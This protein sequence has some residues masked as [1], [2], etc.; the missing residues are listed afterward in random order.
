MK[1]NCTYIKLILSIVNKNKNVCSY[2]M[3][4]DSQIIFTLYNCIL[5]LLLC[6]N[7]LLNSGVSCNVCNGEKLLFIRH[8]ENNRL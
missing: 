6:I 3:T 7:N 5:Y 1:I 8:G 2:V 4:K